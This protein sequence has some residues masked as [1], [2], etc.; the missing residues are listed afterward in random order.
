MS[1]SLAR[2]L[3]SRWIFIQ[4]KMDQEPVLFTTK[5]AFQ[6][7]EAA[8]EYGPDFML[9]LERFI[10]ALAQPGWPSG[11]YFPVGWYQK[12]RHSST[13]WQAV[14]ITPQSVA[15]FYLEEMRVDTQ[16]KWYV[17][18][19]LIKGRILKYFLSHLEFDEDTECYRIR[20]WLETGFEMRYLHHESPPIQVKQCE[21]HG[22]ATT[23]HLN[24]G[25]TWPLDF[26]TLRLDNQEQL[27]CAVTEQGLP[28]RFEERAR[29]ALLQRVEEVA[30]GWVI[31]LGGKTIPLLLDGPIDFPGGVGTN[32]QKASNQRDK[33]T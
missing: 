15:E 7:F 10:K 31:N 5:A 28:A 30:S 23:L 8:H 19:H 2:T 22:Q 14:P 13:D 27:Y 3:I 11:S 12:L 20:H 33:K 26:Q 17:G 6:A 24:I 16:G 1:F 32:H 29:W 18:S 4:G 21:M 25:K 9:F